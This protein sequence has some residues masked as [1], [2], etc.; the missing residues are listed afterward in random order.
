[1]A[2]PIRRS[3]SRA[4]RFGRRLTLGPLLNAD[5]RLA[6]LLARVADIQNRVADIQNR[7]DISNA[8]L[9]QGP[10][11][12]N[13]DLRAGHAPSQLSHEPQPA[14]RA[15]LAAKLDVPAN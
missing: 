4:G 9:R 10:E 13:A 6:D 8:K 3:L 14:D 7:L 2:G 11:A 1:M 12:A 15:R 5:A